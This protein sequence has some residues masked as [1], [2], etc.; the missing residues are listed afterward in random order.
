MLLHE[1]VESGGGGG[2]SVGEAETIGGRDGWVRMES[3]VTGGSVKYKDKHGGGPPGQELGT[4]LSAQTKRA[5]TQKKCHLS[6]AHSSPAVNQCSQ[7]PLLPFSL[8]FLTN[9]DGS[10]RKKKTA[11]VTPKKVKA[12]RCDGK[13][14]QRGKY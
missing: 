3:S 2:R 5:F 8:F 13:L 4:P 1:W 6:T 10:Q 9:I 11:K 12:I 7:K 14:N